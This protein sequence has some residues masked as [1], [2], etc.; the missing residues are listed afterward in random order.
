MVCVEVAGIAKGIDRIQLQCSC[1]GDTGPV[2][3]NWSIARAKGFLWSKEIP[4]LTE[5][6]I[7]FMPYKE[8]LIFSKNDRVF[9]VSDFI[10]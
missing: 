9:Q 6:F 10:L 3:L 1:L 2:S 7:K 5:T 8:K 4:R